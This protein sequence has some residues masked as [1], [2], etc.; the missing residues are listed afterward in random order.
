MKKILLIIAILFLPSFAWCACSTT[1]TC[2]LGESGT[3]RQP[4]DCTVTKAQECIDASSSGDGV[5]LPT[6]TVTWTDAEGLTLKAGVNLKGNGTSNT[7]ITVNTTSGS[8]VN[9]SHAN[10]SR[11]TAIQWVGATGKGVLHGHGVSGIRIDNNIFAGTALNFI[12]FDDDTTDTSTGL[13][14][15][16]TFTGTASSIY[17]FVKGNGY[18]AFQSAV[19]YNSA[20]WVFVENNT[21]T[22]NTPGDAFETHLGGKMVFRYNNVTENTQTLTSFI[23]QHEGGRAVVANNNLITYSLTG[24]AQRAFY[25]RAGTALIY[26]NDIIHNPL[27]SQPAIQFQNFRAMGGVNHDDLDEYDCATSGNTSNEDMSS[28]CVGCRARCCSSSYTSGGYT[29]EGYPCIYGTSQGVRGGAAEPLYFWG[30]RV[31]TDGGSTWAN[32]DNSD[33][34]VQADVAWAIAYNTD[35]Y[36][37]NPSITTYTC[38]HPLTGMTGTC[39]SATAGV[40]GYADNLLTVTIAGTGSG[41]VTDNVASLSETSTFTHYFGGQ[42]VTLTA[43]ALSGSSFTGW[44]GETCSGTGTCVLTVSADK[45]V[46][47]TFD[48]SGGGTTGSI[49]TGTTGSVGLSASG[50]GSITIVP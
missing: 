33:V 48:V 15:T 36:A 17:I 25:I 49:A 21:F 32:L 11:I 40:G 16:N 39:N 31:S 46:T 27:Q 7:I 2:T 8:G 28:L 37:S 30:N 42:E 35:W 47:A 10:N 45:S 14:D 20:N 44:S 26:Q 29:G 23:D 22:L 41:T 13:I 50:T 3:C 18:K 5:Y 43:T 34:T 4:A 6:C 38:P 1:V 19:N 12:I 24:T 9:F